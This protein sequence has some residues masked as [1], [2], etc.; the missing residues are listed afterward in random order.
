[1]LN[2]R[3]YWPWSSDDLRSCSKVIHSLA[4]IKIDTNNLQY[5]QTT[6]GSVTDGMVV[7]IKGR[8]PMLKDLVWK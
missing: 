7:H 5:I 2:L 1:M 6:E 8:M 4:V 3:L